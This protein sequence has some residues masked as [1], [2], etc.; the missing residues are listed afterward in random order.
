MR[1]TIIL[2]LA[3]LTLTASAKPKGKK[4]V[5]TWPDGTV[6]DAWFMEKGRVDVNTLG[7]QYVLTDYGVLAGSTEVQT[8]QIQAVIDRC[9]QEGGG[10]VVVPTGTFKTGALFFKQGTHLH[11]S[12]GAVL[13][14]SDRIIDFPIL[15]TR[16]EGETCKY[17]AALVNAD[18]LDG[19]TI[20]GK[21]TIDGNG[22]KYWQEF[23]I[24]R[25]WNPQCTNKDAQRPRLT[26]VSNSRNV[27][28]QDVHLINSPFWT[29]HVYKSDHVR[30]LD[31]YIYAP[32][33]NVYAPQPKRGAPSSDAIDIDVC[34]DVMVDGC[35][36][37]VN[38]DAVVLKGGK[39][40]WADKDSTNG[41]C[42]RIL[43]QNCHYGRV[44][45]CLTLGSESLHDRN[46]ILRN[47]QTDNANRVLWLKMRPDTPQ[48]YEYVL[49]ENITGHCDRFLFIHPWTQF[50]KPG[51]RKDMPL[52]RCNNVTLRNIKVDTKTMLDVKTSEKYELIDFTLDG[53]PIDFSKAGSSPEPKVFL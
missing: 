3:V 39:G 35:F 34:T 22:L 5:E 31:C 28:I 37:H 40:T 6:M 32:T 50:F 49:V 12:E 42:E 52:S 30:Y 11:L 24:R 8:R 48:H 41:N 20:T 33:E 16:I 1:K 47:C 53:Q 44:H 29:N 7:R 51:D 13:L 43:I 18:G 9:A 19:F 15:T 36:M 14:G 4:A 2:L 38:D 10:V 25:Q 27:T 45:G 46:V 23:W 26:Y 21:G 17:F